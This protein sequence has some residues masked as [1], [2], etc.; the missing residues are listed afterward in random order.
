MDFRT[1]IAGLDLLARLPW[2][3][4]RRFTINEA[5]GFQARQLRNRQERFLRFL[6]KAIYAFPNHPVHQLLKH[7]GCAYGDLEAL[8]KRDGV[9]ETLRNL[10]QS[11]VYLTVDEFKGRRPAV[12]G[13]T[14][15]AVN[16]D[17][18]RNPLA[19]FHIPGQSGGS[20]SA[21]TPVLFDLAFVRACAVAYALYL[22]VRGGD[23][24]LKVIWET[25]G[26][27]ARFRLM[28]MSCFG[29]RPAAWFSQVDPVGPAAGGIFRWSERALRWGALFGGVKLPSPVWASLEDPRPLLHW[30]RGALDRNETPHLFSFPSSIVRL[31]A[32]ALETGIDIRGTKATLSGEPTTQARLDISAE[33]GI[34]SVPRYGSMES[35]PVAYACL[36][37]DTADNTHILRD[38]HAVIQAGKQG[39]HI[40]MP[41]RALL[42][43]S[44]HPAAPF[45]MLNFSMGDEADM[46]DRDCGCPMQQLGWTPHLTNIRSYEKLTAGGMTFHDSDLIGVLD[47]VLPAQFGGHPAD[48]QLVEQEDS[49]GRPY[50]VLVVHPRLG[51]LDATLIEDAFLR[52]IGKSPVEGLM[53][54]MW[55]HSHIVRVERRAPLTTASSKILHLHVERAR[56]SMNQ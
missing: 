32:S 15:I 29:T 36:N 52:A 35:G 50:L 18:L 34:R 28:K 41:S 24:W 51:P 49:N 8:V 3:L 56:S 26:A 45:T 27:G 30:I 38:L 11:G 22:H 5:R 2:F 31:A 33:A 9:E 17:R 19:A 44:L 43:T 21:G 16:P 40:G 14:T 53:A 7:A 55:R 10:L 48:Y 23:D 39:Q 47:R 37:P 6:R 12:R 25:P 20:R 13:S 4:N 46:A 1:A 54:S 42:I